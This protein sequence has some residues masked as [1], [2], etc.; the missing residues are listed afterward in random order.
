MSSLANYS[1]RPSAAKNS[2][3]VS[4][5][6]PSAFSLITDR[7]SPARPPRL[8]AAAMCPMLALTE[9]K[10]V[11]PTASHGTQAW[12]AHPTAQATVLACS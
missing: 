11:S 8:A 3:L 4:V 9:L 10:T 12:S 1:F 6:V 7:D 2:S 5:I